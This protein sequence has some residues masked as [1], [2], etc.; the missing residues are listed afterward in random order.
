[1]TA[2]RPAGGTHAPVGD[3]EGEVEDEYERERRDQGTEA[4]EEG[5]GVL[6][7]LPIRPEPRQAREQGEHPEAAGSRLC[8]GEAARREQSKAGGQVGHPCGG[9]RG[10]VG[11]LE[12]AAMVDREKCGDGPGERRHHHGEH[13][14]AESGGEAR[15]RHRPIL[16]SGTLLPATVSAERI[17]WPAAMCRA[18]G[19][20][21]VLSSHR[22]E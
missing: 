9:E 4:S 22:E 10:G 2:T 1:M 11:G 8:R 5:L 12:A 13:G 3:R 7:A 15:V 18:P 20:R 14:Q 6:R 17:L 21:T 19:D 16:A